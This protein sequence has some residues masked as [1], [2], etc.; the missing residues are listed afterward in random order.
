[1]RQARMPKCRGAMEGESHRRWEWCWDWYGSYT[2]SSQTDPAGPYAGS[3]RVLRGG[4][5]NFDADPPAFIQSRRR[6]AG[7]QARQPG[8]PPREDCGVSFCFFKFLPFG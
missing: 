2:A 8:L 3:D 5:W 4:G 7:R 1:M 6:L